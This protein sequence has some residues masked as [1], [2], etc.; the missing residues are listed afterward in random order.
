MFIFCIF[1]KFTQNNNLGEVETSAKKFFPALLFIMAIRQN[2]EIISFN[3]LYTIGPYPKTRETKH[4][5]L[6]TD[7]KQ[8]GVGE[9]PPLWRASFCS[10]HNVYKW[11][12]EPKWYRSEWE[13]EA[14]EEEKYKKDSHH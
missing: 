2:S 6:S 13:L 3:Q 8:S 7:D 4:G 14:K 10:K 5:Q 9:K 12:Q 11:K 1:W